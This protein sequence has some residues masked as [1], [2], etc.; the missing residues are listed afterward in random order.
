MPEQISVSPE[1]AAEL[2]NLSTRTIYYAIAGEFGRILPS[3]KIGKRRVILVS[4]L[5]Q[6][7][8]EFSRQAEGV[9]Q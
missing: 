6:W 9:G 7:V 3:A 2:T 4:D 5:T 1:K 8:A